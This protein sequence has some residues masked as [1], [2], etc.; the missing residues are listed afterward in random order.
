MEI[1]WI[2]V[3]P[4]FFLAFGVGLLLAVRRLSKDLDADERARSTLAE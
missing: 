2:T 4:V 1:D 3:A